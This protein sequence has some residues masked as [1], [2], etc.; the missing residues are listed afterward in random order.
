[1]DPL[2]QEKIKLPL[3]HAI[4][5]ALR[6]PRDEDHR[7][8]LDETRSRLAQE[9]ILRGEHIFAPQSFDLLAQGVKLVGPQESLHRQVN[10]LAI[11]ILVDMRRWFEQNPNAANHACLA[12]E[13]V[14][15][16]MAAIRS[17]TLPDISQLTDGLPALPPEI[18]AVTSLAGVAREVIAVLCVAYAAE[19]PGHASLLYFLLSG[20]CSLQTDQRISLDRYVAGIEQLEK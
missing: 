14:N 8:A 11:Q 20:G 5:L 4:E 9:E 17:H 19:N 18:A 3:L 1:M 16:V 6:N 15:I 7:R 2:D 13:L 12:N 10:L